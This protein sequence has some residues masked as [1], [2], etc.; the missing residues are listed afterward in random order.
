MTDYQERIDNANIEKNNINDN[1]TTKTTCVNFTR[2]H[3][4]TKE[5][6][7]TDALHNEK[8]EAPTYYL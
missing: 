1:K 7:K 5:E 6:P 3:P 2:I 4:A 8:E